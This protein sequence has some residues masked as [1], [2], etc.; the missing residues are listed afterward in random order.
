M[1]IKIIVAEPWNFSSSDGDNILF[2][3]VVNESEDDKI[4]LIRSKFSNSPRY[5]LL[6]KRDVYGNYNIYGIDNITNMDVDKQEILMIG[7]IVY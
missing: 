7:K 4:V 1:E 3:K 6:K 2:A 5:L